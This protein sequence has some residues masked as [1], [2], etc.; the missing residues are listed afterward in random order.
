MVKWTNPSVV[1]F[2]GTDDPVVKIQ[3]RAQQLTLAAFE[4]GWVGPPYNPIK[5]AEM[6]GATVVPN[7]DISDARTIAVAGKAVIEFNPNRV[8]E[9]VR[10]SIAHEVAHLLFSDAL[11]EIRHRGG[12]GNK[13]D[14]WQLEMLCNMAAA[15]FVMPIGSFPTIEETVSLAALMKRRVDFDV[16]AEAFMIRLAK[17]VSTS[18]GVFCASP[19]ESEG[20]W[21]YRIDYYIPSAMAPT[22]NIVGRI[23]P[24]ESSAYRCTAIGFTD[25]GTE[26]WVSDRPLDVEYVGIPAYPGASLP[27][28]I[29]L[30]H[31]ERSVEG[32]SP[33]KFVQ[34]NALLARG[35]GPKIICQL[36]NDRASKWG[37]GLASQTARK[38]PFAESSFSEWMIAS[39]KEALGQMH[40]VDIDDT[41]A[42]ASLVAQAGFGSSVTP[43][44]RYNALESALLRLSEAASARGASVHMPRI[45]M[46]SAR[47]DWGT[48][49]SLLQDTLVRRG[50]NI[51]VYEMPPKRQQLELF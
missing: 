21:S 17:S 14:E 29:G 27:R 30:I 12:S 37:G 11:D 51:T 1:A 24:K 15:E 4:D 44:I 33:I 19:F 46:G 50:V 7:S 49:E 8:R 25:F 2:S 13:R 41:T 38:Y 26:A 36:V 42:I 47:G 45:G 28:V 34:G 39:R 40:L 32:H 20:A 9:R 3:A 23:I 31:Y 35:D 43:R 5:I 48:I 6:L 18:V 16:S 22:P 10:F